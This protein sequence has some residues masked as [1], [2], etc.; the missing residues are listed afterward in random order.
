[1]T[2]GKGK[3]KS[4]N[5]DIKSSGALTSGSHTTSTELLAGDR[6]QHSLNSSMHRSP[7]LDPLASPNEETPTGPHIESTSH[8]AMSPVG[9]VSFQGYLRVKQR[10]EEKG[11]RH[12]C[13]LDDLTIKCFTSRQGNSSV[14]HQVSLKGST[15]TQADTE[16]KKKHTF[17]VWHASASTSLPTMSLSTNPGSLKS[18]KVLTSLLQKYPRKLQERLGPLRSSTSQGTV[19]LAHVPAP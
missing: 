18:L 8:R 16:A 2:F 7:S 10:P 13:V 11:S 9:T 17:R 4:M 15:I 5:R 14:I 12:W 19:E 6:N 1:M 3:R